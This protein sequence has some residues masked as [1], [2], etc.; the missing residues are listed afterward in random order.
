MHRRECR[1]MYITIEAENA[2]PDSLIRQYI[3]QVCFFIS[4]N[5]I[6]RHIKILHIFAKYKRIKRSHL[7]SQTS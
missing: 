7:L 2:A 1:V 3:M 4:L 5:Y 6:P